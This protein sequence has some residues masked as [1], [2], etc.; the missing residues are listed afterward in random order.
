MLRKLCNKFSLNQFFL[1]S[2]YGLKNHTHQENLQVKVHLLGKVMDV[3]LKY[4]ELSENFLLTKVVEW[5]R[6]ILIGTS[7]TITVHSLADS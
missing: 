7:L 1:I 6:F 2:L 5:I 3:H 4:P